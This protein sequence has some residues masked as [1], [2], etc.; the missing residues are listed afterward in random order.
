MCTCQYFGWVRTLFAHRDTKCREFDLCCGSCGFYNQVDDSRYSICLI[1]K[2]QPSPEQYNESTEIHSFSR[3]PCLWNIGI[4]V[5][6]AE[7]N[8][9]P[10]SDGHGSPKATA[11]KKREIPYSR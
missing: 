6:E 4:N 9:E 10:Q 7:S 11:R 1:V 3:S 8:A 5:C 2:F